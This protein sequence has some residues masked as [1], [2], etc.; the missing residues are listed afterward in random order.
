[1]DREAWC[2]A[3]RGVVK[4]QMQLRPWC[5]FP[6]QTQWGESSSLLRLTYSAGLGRGRGMSDTAWYVGSAHCS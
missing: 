5:L 2:D 3:V 4:S 1:M 6:P